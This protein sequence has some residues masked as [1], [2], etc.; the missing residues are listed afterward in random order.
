ME[1]IELLKLIGILFVIVG[2]ALK[3]DSILII[4]VATVITALVGNIGAI[5]LFELLGTTFVNNRMMLISILIF[6]VAFTL[7]RNGQG[8][9]AATLMKKFKKATPGLLIAIYGIIR[10]LFA[11]MKVDFGSLSAFI[12]PVLVPMEEGAIVAQGK[13]PAKQH[14]EELKGMSA[15]MANISNF[16]GQ[17]LFVG[18]SGALL[19]Q[20]SLNELGYTVELSELVVVEIP[21]FIISMIVACA[22][23]Y[24]K[25]RTM[26]KKFY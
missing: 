9:A 11:T 2:F 1:S 18:S 20:G 19:V 10:G 8:E 22:F 7:E 21:V 12:R 17:V 5:E 14:M 23:F 25:D 4:F 24:V 16:F 13:V 6:L 26:L 15:G 3:L